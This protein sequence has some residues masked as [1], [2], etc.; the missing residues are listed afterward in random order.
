MP[1]KIIFEARPLSVIGKLDEWQLT[2][3]IMSGVLEAAKSKK[4]TINVTNEVGR[5]FKV[6]DIGGGVMNW[7][8]GGSAG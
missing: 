7:G 4:I 3:T 1:E 8:V 2:K 6:I 5:P